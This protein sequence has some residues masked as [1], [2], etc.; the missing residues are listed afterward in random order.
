MNTIFC[1]RLYYSSL[2]LEACQLKVT[3]VRTEKMLAFIA[4]VYS[5]VG[6]ID[7]LRTLE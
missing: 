1:I 2:F 7:H 5:Q 6:G 4:M 3:W